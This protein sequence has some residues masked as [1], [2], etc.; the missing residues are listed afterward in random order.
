AVLGRWLS[1]A[2]SPTTTGPCQLADLHPPALEDL[3]VAGC[4]SSRGVLRGAL[5]ALRT[6]WAQRLTVSCN[7][8]AEVRTDTAAAE[9]WTIAS[10]PPVVHPRPYVFDTP[11]CD[12]L[13]QLDRPGK[14]AA[15]PPP[16]Q[17]G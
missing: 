15:V 7:S 13:A 8:D 16:P 10:S 9:Q 6:V 4:L 2:P 5:S 11:R 14:A 1:A 17:R 3:L 12:S